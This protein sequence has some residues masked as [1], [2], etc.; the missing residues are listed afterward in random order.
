MS[1][2]STGD[3]H[4]VMLYVH[5]VQVGRGGG[6]P[7]RQD[8]ARPPD[9]QRARRSRELFGRVHRAEEGGR[10]EGRRLHPR[11]GRLGAVPGRH[12]H[13][14]PRHQADRQ[15]GLLP[16]RS[17]TPVGHPALPAGILGPRPCLHCGRD[18]RRRRSAEQELARARQGPARY[19]RRRVRPRP[20]R[21]SC[22]STSPRSR[23]TT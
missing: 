5:R 2:C 3:T 18:R 21:P 11:P 16:R 12:D 20:K 4:K 8:H 6:R 22:I 10:G 23:S 14:R 1:H 7:H 13:L 9:S 19:H 17:G 15:P